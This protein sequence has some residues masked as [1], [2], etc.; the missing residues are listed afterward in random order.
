LLSAKDAA[1]MSKDSCTLTPLRTIRLIW[2]CG[3]I[4]RK[5]EKAARNGDHSI[6]LF[7][8]KK[9]GRVYFSKIGDFYKEA[10]F[11]VGYSISTFDGI[12]SISW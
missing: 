9:F 4:N 12:M 10:G 11:C 8:S 7:R 6:Y 3:I 1:N 5:I 2:I